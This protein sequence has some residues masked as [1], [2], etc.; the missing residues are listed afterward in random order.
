MMFKFKIGDEVKITAGRD[1]GAKGKLEKVFPKEDK[2][3]VAGINL[4][5]RHRKATRNK[6][7]GIYEIARPVATA[8]IAIICPKCSKVTRVGFATEAKTK[9]RICKKCQGVV[10]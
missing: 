5:K 1:K 6:P 8:N 9:H 3:V 4:Y 7:A 2:V 10:S